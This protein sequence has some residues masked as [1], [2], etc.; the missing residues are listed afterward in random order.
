MQI[1]F[2]CS[3]LRVQELTDAVLN[4]LNETLAGV[5][6]EVFDNAVL[7]QHQSWEVFMQS[8]SSIAGSYANSAVLMEVPLSR[9][10]RRPQYINAVTPADVQGIIARLLANGPAKVVLFQGQ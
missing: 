5:V 1:G 6:Q 2:A 3:P 9:L 4:L 7:A 10:Q 8:N